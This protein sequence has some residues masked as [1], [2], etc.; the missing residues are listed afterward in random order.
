LEVEKKP[1]LNQI[2][3]RL[4]VAYLFITVHGTPAD[5][6]DWKGQDSVALK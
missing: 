4:A 1:L 3:M 5:E 6:N 2:A